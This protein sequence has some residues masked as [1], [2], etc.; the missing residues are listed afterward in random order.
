[1]SPSCDV[2]LDRSFGGQARNCF[3]SC[4]ASV[5]EDLGDPGVPIFFFFSGGRC[6]PFPSALQGLNQLQ[7]ASSDTELPCAKTPPQALHGCDTQNPHQALDGCDRHANAP[8][9]E[10]K[11]AGMTLTT[12]SG[13]AELKAGNRFVSCVR[14]VGMSSELG[15]WTSV[16]RDFPFSLF[17]PGRFPLFPPPTPISYPASAGFLRYRALLWQERM[18]GNPPSQ[19]F[20]GRDRDDSAPTLGRGIMLV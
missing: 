11:H 9:F 6:P 15:G 18:N 16:V 12:P 8:M 17:R 19:G 3:G 1:M 13:G 20:D 7:L 14:A 5:R 10:G 2:P 4:G